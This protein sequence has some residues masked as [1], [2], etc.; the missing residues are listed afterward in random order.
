MSLFECILPLLKCIIPSVY[1]D[2]WEN[3]SEKYIVDF[4]KYR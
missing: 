1:N 4:Y 3:S 2:N